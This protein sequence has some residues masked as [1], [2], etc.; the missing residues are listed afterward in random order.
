MRNG[1][2][3][4]GSCGKIFSVAGGSWG[5]GPPIST[6]DSEHDVGGEFPLWVKTAD[7]SLVT[8]VAERNSILSRGEI[9]FP[10]SCATRG[11]VDAPMKHEPHR[12]PHSG[13]QAVTHH[14]VLQ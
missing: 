7:F 9:N 13:P 4:A 14:G 10:I 3:L 6:F 5:G 2:A 8:D 12:E 1:Q 11:G